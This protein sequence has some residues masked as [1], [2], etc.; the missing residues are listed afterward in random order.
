METTQPKNDITELRTLLFETI[1]NL[2][3]GEKPMEIE[4]AKAIAAMIK[5]R[6][7]IRVTP[8][9]PQANMMH[10]MFDAPQAKV[11]AAA[12]EVSAETGLWLF[13]GLWNRPFAA[14]PVTEVTVGEATMAAGMA[15]LATLPN[16]D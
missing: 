9:V 5:Q 4:R 2:K 11:E 12:V 7:F 8:D 6:D 13:N 15:L 1:R 16:D 14:E 3:D 10:L